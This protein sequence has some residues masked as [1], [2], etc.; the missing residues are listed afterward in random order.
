[1][2]RSFK[3]Y[4]LEE[5]LNMAYSTKVVSDK[6]QTIPM[7]SSVLG[8]YRPSTIRINDEMMADTGGG[9]YL[10]DYG[11]Q[12]IQYGPRFDIKSEIPYADLYG[13][14]GHE[15]AHAAEY[16]AYAKKAD[17]LTEIANP[18]MLTGLDGLLGM[19]L[20]KELGTKGMTSY[21]NIGQEYGAFS[22]HRAIENKENYE[23]GREAHVGGS[24]FLYMGDSRKQDKFYRILFGN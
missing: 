7:G 2:P 4:N 23:Q 10:S 20:K 1:S 22:I 16:R 6:G 8:N 15:G 13:T 9:V 24:N 19:S 5:M 3:R 17:A 12:F 18:S 21:H 11:D 14:L